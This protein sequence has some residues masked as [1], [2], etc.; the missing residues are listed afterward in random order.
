MFYDILKDILQEIKNTYVLFMDG[1]DQDDD[2]GI[3]RLDRP[4]STNSDQDIFDNVFSNPD[5]GSSA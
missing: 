4:S 2:S 1:E 5:T 3:I